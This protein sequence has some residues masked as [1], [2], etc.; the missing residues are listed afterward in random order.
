[1]LPVHRPSRA[2]TT[3]AAAV[4]PRNAL[5][6]PSGV[7]FETPW[8]YLSP[9]DVGACFLH[10]IRSVPMPRPTGGDIEFTFPFTFM[11]G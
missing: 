8:V 2:G 1:M 11:P 4:T 10:P 3:H 7:E 5:R 6:V 9:T